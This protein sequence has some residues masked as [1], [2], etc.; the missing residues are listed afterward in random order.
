[1]PKY[2]IH[3]VKER[4]EKIVVG[5]G[6]PE[7]SIFIYNKEYMII[8]FVDGKCSF[9]RCGVNDGSGEFYYN[10]LD[11]LYNAVTVDGILLKR[12]WNDI[13]D[14]ACPD[15]GWFTDEDDSDLTQ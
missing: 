10:S 6:L 8:V 5:G 9:Q 1:M 2:S 15:Y 11:E 12:D 7:L 14:F 13:T 4:L 3:E